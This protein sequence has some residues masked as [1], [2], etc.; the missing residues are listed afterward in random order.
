MPQKILQLNIKQTELK[1]P[2]YASPVTPAINPVNQ[3]AGIAYTTYTMQ[4]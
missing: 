2:S 3:F 4:D 1:E